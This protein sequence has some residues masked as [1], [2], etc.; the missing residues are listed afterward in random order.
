MV[1]DS[2]G[3]GVLYSVH[4]EA[5]WPRCCCLYFGECLIVWGAL[6]LQGIG[7]LDGTLAP[8]AYWPV[9]LSVNLDRLRRLIV[10]GGAG[11]ALGHGYGR[12]FAA[13]RWFVRAI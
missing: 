10:R 3:G 9:V 5:D 13:R 2:L 4:Y 6:V 12:N 8:V 11:L 1:V 7:S